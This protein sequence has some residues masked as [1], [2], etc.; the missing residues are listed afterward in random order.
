VQLRSA[1]GSAQADAATLAAASRL[2]EAESYGIRF[3]Q[4]IE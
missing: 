3:A 2:H 1:G 4:R